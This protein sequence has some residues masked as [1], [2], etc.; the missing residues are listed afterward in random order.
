MT[1]KYTGRSQDKMYRGDSINVTYNAR[2]CIHAGECLSRLAAVFDV[3]KRPWITPNDASADEVA[4]VVPQCPSGALHFEHSDLVEPVLQD[5]II[6]L[7]RNGP[8]QLQGNL[9]IVGTAV[10]I[11]YETRV[12]LC[13][14]GASNN[15]PFCDNAHKHINFEAVEVVSNDQPQLQEGEGELQIT[16]QPDGPIEL[17]GNVTIRN[18]HGEVF[19][20]GHKA[21]LCRC[22]HSIC[23]PLC[24]GTHKSIGFKAE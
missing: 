2:R 4:T 23:K 14:C 21:K 18:R 7:W 11:E 12:T 20:T 3:N 10:E 13:R 5:N 9:S 6:I 1:R 17:E 24:D 22:G 16:I 15:K 19:F 8:V